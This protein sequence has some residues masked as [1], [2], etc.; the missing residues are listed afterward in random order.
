ML[1][2]VV[3][4]FIEIDAGE[5]VLPQMVETRKDTLFLEE[6]SVDTAEAAKL[7]GK[8]PLTIRRWIK[9]GKLEARKGPGKDN[10]GHFYI[11]KR[12]LEKALKR[13]IPDVAEN[14]E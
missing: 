5:E 10:K 8:H 4:C 12:S 11:T 1:Y 7:L 14:G 9:A 13:V 6:E 2:Y 3:L